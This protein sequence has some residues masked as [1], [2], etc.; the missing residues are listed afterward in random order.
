[1]SP[2][3]TIDYESR[4]KDALGGMYSIVKKSN[5]FFKDKYCFTLTDAY[6]SYIMFS[7]SPGRKIRKRLI[8]KGYVYTEFEPNV[9]VW[10]GIGSDCA[11]VEQYLKDNTEVKIFT[12]LY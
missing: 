10:V 8:S 7:Y 6:A 5:F 9:K 2:I 4:I 1:M 12:P 11:E 3:E